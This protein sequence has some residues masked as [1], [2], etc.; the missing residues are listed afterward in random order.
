MD[1]SAH[2]DELITLRHGESRPVSILLVDD[3]TIVLELIAL[4][5]AAKGTEVVRALGG[6]RG[7]DLLREISPPPDVVLVDHQ[8]PE[9]SGADVARF[10]RTMPEPRPRLVAM[11]ASPLPEDELALFDEFLAKPV[12]RDLLRAAIT[13][14][15]TRPSAEP[16]APPSLPATLDAATIGKLRAM[17]PPQALR[18]LFTVYISDTR[19]RIDELERCSA[20]NDQEGLR[21][22]AH[23]LKGAAAMSGVQGVATIAASLEAGEVPFEEQPNLFRQLRNACDDVER[24]MI[25]TTPSGEAR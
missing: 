2:I 17:M 23:A 12:D 21:R 6:Q 4:L 25:S 7:I 15:S 13:G 10:V 16:P 24:T 14:R 5:L 20:Y 1:G 11:S 9:V 3:D 22:C 19:Q 8:M 18:E